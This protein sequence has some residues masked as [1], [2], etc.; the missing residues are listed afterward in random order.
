MV[1]N[2]ILLTSVPKSGTHLLTRVAG[3]ATGGTFRAARPD[4]ALGHW[5]GHF[6]IWTLPEIAGSD[7]WSKIVLIRDPRDVLLSLQD[8]LRRSHHP[9]HRGIWEKIGHLTDRDRLRALVDGVKVGAGGVPAWPDYFSGWLDW[10]AQGALLLR[11]ET[12]RHPSTVARLA[13]ALDVSMERVHYALAASYGIEGRT[14]NVGISGRWVAELHDS[15]LAYMQ[16]ADDGILERMGYRWHCSMTPASS[17]RRDSAGAR[18]AG[19][20]SDGPGARVENVSGRVK[21]TSAR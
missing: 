4:A 11:Y 13:A 9:D 1:A 3:M 21:I 18:R 16:A 17:W 8:F 12:I 7:Q 19:A 6:R 2:A 14:L 20:G 10:E 15:D 5:Y